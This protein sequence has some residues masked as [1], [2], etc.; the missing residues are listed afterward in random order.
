MFGL[1]VTKEGSFPY[2]RDK[3][4]FF[5]NIA[6]RIVPHVKLYRSKYTE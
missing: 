5:F 2:Y 3:T 6:D 1:R 4:W